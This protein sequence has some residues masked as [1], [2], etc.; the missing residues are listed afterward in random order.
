MIAAMGGQHPSTLPSHADEPWR[1]FVGLMIQ[2][3]PLHMAPNQL[4]RLRDEPGAY[5]FPEELAAD[6]R[7]LFNGLVEI[8]AGLLAEQDVRPVLRAVETFGFHL[9]QLDI[10]QNS[11]Y[12]DEAMGQLLSAAGLDGAQFGDWTEEERLRFLDRELRS[13]RP[14]LHANASAGP[15]AD[16]VLE[17]Y[18]V[19][20][21][22]IERWGSA[23]IGAL[24]VS[25]TKR[26]SDLLVVYLLAREA[27][28]TRYSAGW[29]R[30]PAAHRPA[31]RDHLRSRARPGHPARVPGSPRHA[32]QPAPATGRRGRARAAGNGRL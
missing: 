21:R 11:A 20:G 29:A 1:D 24:I 22:H 15:E 12:H 5:R 32:R 31:L 17:C 28:L 10:R 25:M 9:A 8:G 6:L 19:L 16:S 18:R 2:R 14:F 3:L 30:L 7:A 27:G 13:P 26:R 4:A 23:G